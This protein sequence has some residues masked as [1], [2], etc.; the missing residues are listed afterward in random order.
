MAGLI[1]AVI[2]IV[3][4]VN[5][6][7]TLFYIAGAMVVLVIVFALFSKNG[8]STEAGRENTLVYRPHYITDDE[9]ECGNYGE[10]FSRSASVC[11]RCGARFGRTEKNEDEYDDELEEELEMDEWDEEEDR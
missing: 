6:D 5:G 10:R 11:P 1:L 7:W 8:K 3:L 4:A 2:M 9:Y